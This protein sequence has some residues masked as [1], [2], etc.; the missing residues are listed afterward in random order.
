MKNPIKCRVSP[1][2]GMTQVKLCVEEEDDDAADDVIGASSDA[3]S[4]VLKVVGMSGG[5]GEDGEGA[6]NAWIQQIKE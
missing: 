5:S 2:F 4:R 1:Q 3:T 6:E